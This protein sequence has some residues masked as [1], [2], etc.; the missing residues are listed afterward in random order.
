MR[1]S[2]STRALVAIMLTFFMFSI[3]GPSSA[4]ARWHD[5]SPKTD[6]FPTG[7]AIAGGIV[8]V[9]SIVYLMVKKS[10]KSDQDAKT[11][12]IESDSESSEDAKLDNYS[13]DPVA[14][15]SSSAVSDRASKVG[16]YF[17]I[18]RT[19]RKV[20]SDSPAPITNDLTLHVGLSVGF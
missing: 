3:L 2:K 7:L 18:D 4:F 20:V 5:N 14:F 19:G 17:G 12:E 16:L 15:A 8:V 11:D 6:G 10:H 9:G 1:N 13:P